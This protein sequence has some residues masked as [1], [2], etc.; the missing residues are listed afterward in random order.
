MMTNTASILQDFIPSRIL[1][2]T[3]GL[4]RIR[5]SFI[6]EPEIGIDCCPRVI[7]LSDSE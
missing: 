4:N 2:I 1:N 3:I 6:K 7:E 5:K